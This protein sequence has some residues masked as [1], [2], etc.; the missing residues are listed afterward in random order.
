MRKREKHLNH[1][2]AGKKP[3]DESSSKS[4]SSTKNLKNNSKEPKAP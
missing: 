3:S 2:L 1:Y 4:V